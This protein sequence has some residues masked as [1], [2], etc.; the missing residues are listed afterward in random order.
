VIEGHRDE[1]L[2]DGEPFSVSMMLTLIIRRS[3]E[4]PILNVDYNTR[5]GR[6]K[7][8]GPLDDRLLAFVNHM[9]GILKAQADH[10]SRPATPATEG[11]KS[12]Q[13]L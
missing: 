4:G 10:L 13:G 2:D 3:P 11:R 12:L 5:T 1:S 8:D 6:I 9:V 7:V